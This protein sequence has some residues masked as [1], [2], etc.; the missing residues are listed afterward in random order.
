MRHFGLTPFPHST[1]TPTEEELERVVA[2]SRQL[3]DYARTLSSLGNSHRK[4]NRLPQELIV[5]IFEEVRNIE[6]WEWLRLLLVCGEWR[7]AGLS[8][9]TLW[10]DIT[11]Q[12]IGVKVDFLELC[13]VRSKNAALSV[14]FNGTPLVPFRFNKIE[15]HLYRLH[16]LQ[17][18]DLYHGGLKSFLDNTNCEFP[19]LTTFMAE[20]TRRHGGLGPSNRV[21]FVLL[22]S[23]RFPKLRFL[24][25]QGVVVDAT[26]SVLPKLVRLSLQELTISRRSLTFLIARCTS[27]E[28]LDLHHL[29]F[30]GRRASSSSS[31]YASDIGGPYRLKKLKTLCISA[32]HFRGLYRHLLLFEDSIQIPFGSYRTCIVYGAG[33][34][35]RHS[36]ITDNDQLL[37]ERVGMKAL[38]HTLVLP[39]FPTGSK[40]VNVYIQL[41][42]NSAQ[43]RVCLAVTPSTICAD[44]EYDLR[45]AWRKPNPRWRYSDLDELGR[46]L[47]GTP[48][49]RLDIRYV[50]S[51]TTCQDERGWRAFLA[52]FPDLQRLFVHAPAPVAFT[53]GTTERVLDALQ[54]RSEER[55]SEG[56]FVCTKLQ[57]LV[58]R[59]FNI[60]DR[61]RFDADLSRMLKSRKAAGMALQ[62]MDVDGCLY[63]EPP[64]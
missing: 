49:V 45:S 58:I 48:A 31:E 12:E 53:S 40:P 35:C 38:L 2:L 51:R 8:G 55:V 17:L 52:N 21:A 11:L 54:R 23:A 3:H 41:Y 61:D 42:N 19:T 26:S 47:Q 36:I 16:E 62:Q 25:I 13:L 59:D 7:A 56:A 24:A 9:A 5:R 50:K 34:T 29:F 57:R 15:S 20:E 28:R 4:I 32:P 6:G 27:L 37:Q 64:E 10:S 18:R 46:I 63:T 14:A 30:S 22:N 43:V 33:E 44:L 39:K 60:V 1:Y